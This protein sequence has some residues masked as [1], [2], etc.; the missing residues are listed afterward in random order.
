M[1]VSIV[2]SSHFVFWIWCLAVN[3]KPTYGE[4]VQEGQT[5]LTRQENINDCDSPPH[6]IRCGTKGLIVNCFN[7]SDY[8]SL[9]AGHLYQ[10]DAVPFWLNDDYKN[11]TLTLSL[12]KAVTSGEGAGDAIYEESISSDFEK[13]MN[14]FN[15]THPPVFR[16][17]EICIGLD[18]E[19]LYVN[20]M[21]LSTSDTGSS[22]FNCGRGIFQTGP[23]CINAY[24]SPFIAPPPIVTCGNTLW[25]ADECTGLQ[26][27]DEGTSSAGPACCGQVGYDPYVSKCCA[28]NI[29]VPASEDC[30]EICTEVCMD[31]KDQEGVAVCTYDEKKKVYHNICKTDTSELLLI[32]GETAVDND[33]VVECGC[34]TDDGIRRIKK[35][36]KSKHCD[37][38]YDANNDD[39]RHM[40]VSSSS[41]SKGT[42]HY[43]ERMIRGAN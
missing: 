11:E 42:S 23:L 2:P 12:R 8:G 19:G 32:A 36:R 37:S 10:V 3:L 39:R 6:A 22:Y 30:P 21:H 1:L 34:C 29:V 28:E 40:L 15:F 31:D 14:L 20:R 35:M 5:L 7:I 27:C 24:V 4:P 9:T 33:P 26:C 17:E 16:E 38:H 43:G 18:S 41:S 13:G 25:R